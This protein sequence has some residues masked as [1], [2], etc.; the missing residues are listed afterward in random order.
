LLNN[1]FDPYEILQNHENILN[2]LIQ[3]HNEVAKL[4]ENLAETVVLL[5]RRLEQ[6]ENELNKV[7]EYIGENLT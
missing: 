7:Y 5:N 2:D 3:A 1:E 4:N 6:V